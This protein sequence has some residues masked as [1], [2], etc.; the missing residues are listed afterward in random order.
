M[1]NSF[2][3]NFL[4]NSRLKM[5]ENTFCHIPGIGTGIET[6]LWEQGFLDWDSVL[7]SDTLPVSDKLK[8][9]LLKG[10]EVSKQHLERKNPLYFYTVLPSNQTWRM[11]PAFRDKICYLD[12]ETTG[13]GSP[14]DYITT[15]VIYDGK[16]IFSY[17]QGQNLGD[18]R[19]DIQKY[20]LLVT[21]NGTTFDLPFIRNYF[22]I[23]V[24]QAHIDLRYV[25]RSLGYRGGLK[26]CEKQLGIDR[27][28]LVDVDGFFAVKLWWE[29]LNNGNDGALQTL[30]AYN[31]VDVIDLELLLV[32][33]YNLK[34]KETHFDRSY[35]IVVPNQPEIPFRI[36]KSLLQEFD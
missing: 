14:G 11:F 32:L 20:E 25:L 26:S 33:A 6:K 2:G 27:K 19:Y 13:L 7:N 29:Y 10:V 35:N 36:D 17:V 3:V 1:S 8:D 28:D 24:R 21:Y 16:D 22:K 18:F 5:I 23:P 12:I 30:L 31:T 9:G 4:E 34:L 15:I